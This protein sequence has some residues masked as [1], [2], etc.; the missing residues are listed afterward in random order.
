MGSLYADR[1]KGLLIFLNTL[2]ERD[3]AFVPVAFGLGELITSAMAATETASLAAAELAAE[4]ALAASTLAPALATG[5][6]GAAL[7]GESAAVT[8]AT[9]AGS[10]AAVAGALTESAA[11]VESGTLGIAGTEA[12]EVG[13]TVDAAEAGG[14]AASRSTMSTV[15]RTAAKWGSKAAM[16]GGA[17]AMFVGSNPGTTANIVAQGNRV[18]FG[19]SANRPNCKKDPIGAYVCDLQSTFT[20][21]SC[22]YTPLIVGGGIF[23]GSYVLV[24][25]WRIPAILGSGYICYAYSPMATGDKQEQKACENKGLLSFLT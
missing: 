23:A 16:A 8:S 10:E 11:A 22:T 2:S 17:T 19:N 4:Q 13:L 21:I 20:S 15:A 5:I 3:M 6:E 24:R 25:D 12:G 7:V 14:T 18:F 9:V 1:T